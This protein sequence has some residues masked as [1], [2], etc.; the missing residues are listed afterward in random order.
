MTGLINNPHIVTLFGGTGDLTYRKLLP[1]FLNLHIRKVLDANFHIIVIGR[2]PYTNETYKDILLPWL[3]EHARLKPTNQ[4]LESF[5]DRI[6]YFE[7]VFTREEGYER[8]N[9]YF[10]TLDPNNICRRLYYFAVDPSYF[11]DIATNLSKYDLTTNSNVIIEKP[12][13]N[14]LDSAQSINESLQTIFTQDHIYRIDHYLAKEVVQNILPMRKHPLLLDKWNHEY[15]E[16]VEISVFES[17]GVESRGGFYDA[18]GALKDMVHSHLLQVLSL[19][20]LDDEDIDSSSKLHQAQSDALESLYIEN[21]CTDVI[22]GQY[23]GYTEEPNVDS[24]SK[25]DTYVA[26]K[27]ASHDKRW[28]HVPFYLQ[29]GKKL[30]NRMGVIVIRFK[31]NDQLVLELQPHDKMMLVLSNNDV[32]RLKT[33]DVCGD[34]DA[35]YPEAYERLLL[36][37]TQQ[38][39][40]SFVSYNQ[41]HLCWALIENIIE[42]CKASIIHSYTPNSNGPK[43]K[44]SL[45]SSDSWYL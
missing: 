41:V 29:T 17:V 25:T 42:A 15:I 36:E 22:Y 45:R 16:S 37:A 7:M 9:A 35:S 3:Y 8:L 27:L 38:N 43:A 19:I 34:F 21:P 13:G 1:A 5:L 39:P 6:Q 33:E 32:I 18:T 12:F 10:K 24:N 2:R 26:L 44:N 14:D 40:T 31:N 11:V 23:A 4:E 20:L 30:S 28:T